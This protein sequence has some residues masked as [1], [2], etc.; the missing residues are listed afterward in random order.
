MRNVRRLQCQ[1]RDA[2]VNGLMPLLKGGRE[3]L[4]ACGVNQ[5]AP[6]VPV[7][8]SR[9]PSSKPYSVKP[10]PDVGGA[11]CVCSAGPGVRRPALSASC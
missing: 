9:K 10:S 6:R 4:G 1:T 7:M 2:K 3:R 8:A 11:A 5:A